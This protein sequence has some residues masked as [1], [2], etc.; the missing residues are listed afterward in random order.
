MALTNDRG[1]RIKFDI[2]TPGNIVVC[3]VGTQSFHFGI[4]PPNPPR[5]P[6][7]SDLE[8]DDSSQSST[9]PSGSGAPKTLLKFN[10]KAQYCLYI[11]IYRVYFPTSPRHLQLLL[12]RLVK[13][14]DNSHHS[15][16]TMRNIVIVCPSVRLFI[17]SSH[18]QTITINL[19]AF[20]LMIDSWR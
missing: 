10:V 3:H 6:T 15:Y 19:H 8:S 4:Y 16:G 13:V 9:V 17:G 11:C 2:P 5:S 7:V 20:K 14:L 18:S 12:P 1:F